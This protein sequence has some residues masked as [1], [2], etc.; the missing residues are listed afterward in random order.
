MSRKMKRGRKRMP[1]STKNL[2]KG[3]VVE[4]EDKIRSGF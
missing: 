2:S 4:E 3:P 1:G